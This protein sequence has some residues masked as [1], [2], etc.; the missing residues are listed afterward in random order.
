MS[1]A[2]NDNMAIWRAYCTTPPSITRNVTEGRGPNARTYTT[3][4]AY[5]QIEQATR[6]FGPVGTGWGWDVQFEVVGSEPLAL[7]VAH[8]NLWYGGDRSKVVQ[9]A[10]AVRLYSSSDKYPTRIDEDAYKKA[11]T[12]ALTKGLSY[13]GFGADVF[14]GRFDDNKYVAAQRA[15]EIEGNG[16]GNGGNG[17]NGGSANG[18]G[19]G[20]YGQ[21]S[22]VRQRVAVLARSMGLDP[23][24]VTEAIFDAYGVTKL[25]D[26]DPAKADEFAA[27]LQAKADVHAKIQRLLGSQPATPTL[28]GWLSKRG[29]PTNLLCVPLT[30]WQAWLE[31]LTEASEADAEM[32]R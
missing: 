13:L 19:N 23:V 31:E 15:R 28:Q 12:D 29:E 8:V 18:S 4:C 7:V 9:V 24:A 20:N 1:D 6:M 22:A 32:T 25:Q 21:V 11:L 14:Q 30:Q 26:L 16:S 3:I 27:G 17:G 10:A 5:H 2:Q